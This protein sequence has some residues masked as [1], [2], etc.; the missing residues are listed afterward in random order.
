MERKFPGDVNLKKCWLHAIRHVEGKEFNVNQSTKIC[1]S[2]T[3]DFVKSIGDQRIYVREGVVPSCF[4]ILVT[5]FSAERK[6]C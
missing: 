3:G 5:K 6:A 1:H 2:K 4:Y